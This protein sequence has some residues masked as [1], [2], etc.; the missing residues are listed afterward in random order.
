[1]SERKARLVY[2]IEHAS[3]L[4]EKNSEKRPAVKLATAHIE[5]MG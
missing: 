4:C 3:F 5:R 1:M 2:C